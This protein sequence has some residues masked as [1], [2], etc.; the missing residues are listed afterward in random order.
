MTCEVC[1]G[2]VE[3]GF[4][5]GVPPKGAKYCVLCRSERR[6]RA[7]AKYVWRAEFDEHLKAHYYGG[8]DW[9]FKVSNRMIQ[10]TG[11]PRLYIKRQPTRRIAEP[12][13]DDAAA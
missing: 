11:L 5:H 7:N 12:S 6:R 4:R 8:V 10:L 2:P 9:R 13:G 1:G 3:E